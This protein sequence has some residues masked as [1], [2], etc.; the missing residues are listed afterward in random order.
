MFVGFFSLIVGMVFP[1]FFLLEEGWFGA[2]G[3]L[4]FMNLQ[5][6]IK[7]GI[8]LWLWVTFPL[9]FFLVTLGLRFLPRGFFELALCAV[10]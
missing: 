6:R 2:K 1:L 3:Y 7:R 10:G 5:E 8:F 9:A 4:Y